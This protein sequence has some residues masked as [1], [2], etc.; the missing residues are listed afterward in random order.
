M[1][2]I[3]KWFWKREPENDCKEMA[4]WPASSEESQYPAEDDRK[5]IILVATKP[6]WIVWDILRGKPIFYGRLSQGNTLMENILW[7]F[8]TSSEEN[9]Y[10]TEYDRKKIARWYISSEDIQLLTED[11]RKKI[12]RRQTSSED[13][14]HL[15]E[16][17]RK[18]IS[19]WYTSSEDFQHLTEDDRE[20]IPWRKHPWVTCDILRGRPISYRRWPQGN[21]LMANILG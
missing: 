10:L 19:S 4:C 15:V 18:V 9:Q 16:N 11:D 20:E 5:E 3:L 8:R 21:I 17:D 1:A 12:P 13:I 2:N 6:S 7:W 14:Q